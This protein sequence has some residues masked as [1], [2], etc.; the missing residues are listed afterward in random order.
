MNFKQGNLATHLKAVSFYES[1]GF[2]SIDKK[3]STIAGGFLAFDA[4][5]FNNTENN[6]K[7]EGAL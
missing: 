1:K 3:E 6:N 2:I 7:I 4:K 5:R